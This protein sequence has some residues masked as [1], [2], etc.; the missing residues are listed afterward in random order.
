MTTPTV[1]SS[2][3]DPEPVTPTESVDPDTNPNSDV[4]GVDNSV[5]D[6][7]DSGSS[8]SENVVS[9]GTGDSDSGIN[10]VT[11]NVV[12]YLDPSGTVPDQLNPGTDVKYDPACPGSAGAKPVLTDIQNQMRENQAAKAEGREPLAVRVRC[13]LCGLFH[14]EQQSSVDNLTTMDNYGYENI[15]KPA[16]EPDAP[17]EFDLAQAAA[18]VTGSPI[19]EDDNVSESTG[20]D[21]STT[22]GSSDVQSSGP[23][24]SS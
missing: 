21:P 12:P 10:H 5:Q 6:A 18:A 22:G 11:T 19:I 13:L 14:R 7:E 23:S 15:Q 1:I 8:D 16:P 24:T 9:I 4:S 17:A 20:G 2:S 3:D